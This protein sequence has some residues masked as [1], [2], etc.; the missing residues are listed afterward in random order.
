M[1][2]IKWSEDVMKKFKWYDMKLAQL[3]AIFAILTTITLWPAFLDMV[4][5]VE[6]YLYLVLAIICGAPLVK[7]MFYK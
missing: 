4:L 7:R 1:N 3:A 2:L 6:W 5:K